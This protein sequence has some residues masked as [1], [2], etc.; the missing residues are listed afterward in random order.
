MNERL[1]AVPEV[2]SVATVRQR[3]R[4]IA[5][6]LSLGLLSGCATSVA[7]TNVE[8]AS[9]TLPQP[10]SAPAAPAITVVGSNSDL[11][12]GMPAPL[13][14]HDLYAADRPG[15]LESFLRGVTPRVYVPNS[16]GHTV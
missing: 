2:A 5:V 16:R 10:T 3:R 8:T 1:A 13:D 11:L 15:L 14:P 9:K 7:A 12:P 6:L 4:G